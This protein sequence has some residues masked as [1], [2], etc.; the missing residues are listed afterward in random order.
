MM[1]VGTA[2]DHPPTCFPCGID[3]F[4]GSMS[5]HSVP[6]RSSRSTER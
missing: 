2:L 5:S 1:E 4:A 6:I 3:V